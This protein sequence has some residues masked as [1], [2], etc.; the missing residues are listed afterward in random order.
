VQ[1][2][3]EAQSLEDHLKAGRHFSEAELKQLTQS[4]L[5]ILIYLHRCHPPVI[6]RDIKPSNILLGDRSGHSIGQVYLVD[7][8]SV[9]TI[10]AH[11]GSTITV[12]GTYG[13]MPP[14]QFG[15]RAVAASD[16]YSLGA[17]LIYLATGQHPADLPQTDLR[18][19]FESFVHLSSPLV[20]W[21]QQM[22]APSLDRRF[23]SAEAALAALEHSH[24]EQIAPSFSQR[25]GRNLTLHKSDT[26][27]EVERSPQGWR[28]LWTWM[29]T[30]LFLAPFVGV[31]LHLMLVLGPFGLALAWISGITYGLFFV[32]ATLTSQLGST[33]LR[34]DSS[35]ISQ[36]EKLWGRDWSRVCAPLNHVSRVVYTPRFRLLAIDADGQETRQEVRPCLT[37]WAGVQKFEW[38][39]G[40][41]EPEL[42]WLAQELSDWL[43]LPLIRE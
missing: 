43:G 8:G 38:S 42:E 19:Q 9:Q 30:W 27:I 40:L 41:S 10:A 29:M 32:G 24:S 21:L 1:T 4:I 39:A 11:Q 20:R 13:Y 14:E 22:T 23:A 7:F 34:I 26:V 12:V 37:I 15:G 25:M 35:T 31:F 28:S 3:I 33:H 17:T 5:Q 2:Y 16:L 6:H 36:I 18:L